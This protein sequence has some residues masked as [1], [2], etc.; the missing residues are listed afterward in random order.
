MLK[1]LRC[2]FYLDEGFNA[3]TLKDW[4]LGIFGIY[5]KGLALTMSCLTILI[6]VDKVVLEKFYDYSIYGASINRIHK[7]RQNLGIY[8]VPFVIVFGPLFE[9]L[10]CRLSLKL[11]RSSVAIS[12][13][14]L[15]YFF[16]G[17]HVTRFNPEDL[18]TYIRLSISI[19]VIF[20]FHKFFPMKWIEI[21]KVK[22]YAPFFYFMAIL[23]AL[24]HIGNYSPY[25]RD[26]LLFYPIFILPQLT[27]GLCIGYAR[28]KYGFVAGWAVHAMIN[29]PAAFFYSGASGHFLLFF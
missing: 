3:W 8:F 5:I 26:V 7:A 18:T 21:I 19:I 24:L 29:V 12:M 4:F 25:N 28:V 6:I 17:G 14:F 15:S 10:L 20:S 2:P 13:G 22:Y 11:E 9:E 23:F 1:Y 16:L 27:M